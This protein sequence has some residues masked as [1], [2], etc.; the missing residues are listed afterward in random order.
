VGA[1]FWPVFARKPALSEV[2]GWGFSIQEL[3]MIRALLLVLFTAGLASAQPKA[4]FYMIETPNSVKSFVE[5][6]DKIDVIVPAW[7]SVDGNG[8][9]WGGPNPEVLKVAAEHHVPVMPIV[10]LATQA[11]LH[12]LL[13]TQA[14]KNAF[15]DALVSE[16]K[17]NA[18][19]GFQIDFEN[20]NWTD[21]DLLSALVAE[22]AS[23]LRQEKL[24]LTIATV[25]NAPGFPGKSAFSH[26]LYANWRGSFDLKALAQ[27]VD[28]ICLMTYDQNTRWTMPGPVAGYPWTVENVEY[29]LQFVPKEKLSMG[30]PVY[31]YHWFAG[32]P[33]KDEKPNPTAEYIGQHEIDGYVAAYHPKV[34]WD[35]V[36]RVSWFYFYRDDM[37]DWVFFTDKRGFQERLNIVRDRGLGGFCSWVLGAEDPEIWS[38]LRSHK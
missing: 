10:A 6:A 3:S 8:L 31:G 35:A 1:H 5:H 27:S 15:K 11:E 17:K 13:T 26:W 7:Y 36:D 25:P 14:S 9:V 21:R 29:A 34:E 28:L 23:V 12:K 37:R 20:V 33:G 30:I 24:Q 4:L 2:E 16:S 19:T 22:T 38:M 18:Y 32:D